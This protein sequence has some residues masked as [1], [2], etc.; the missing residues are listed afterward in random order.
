[1]G[2]LPTSVHKLIQS[3]LFFCYFSNFGFSSSRFSCKSK[4]QR[5][6]FY[7]K[8]SE[9][10]DE[11]LSNLTSHSQISNVIVAPPFLFLLSSPPPAPPISADLASGGKTKSKSLEIFHFN[12][13]CD[14]QFS[15]NQ[16]L[17]WKWATERKLIIIKMLIIN[18]TFACDKHT[19]EQQQLVTLIL[20]WHAKTVFATASF[21]NLSFVDDATGKLNNPRGK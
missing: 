5:T 21:V 17:V 3:S 10:K 19:E 16:K 20:P 13:Q 2:K 14:Q 4:S 7:R 18:K 9:R 15:Q 8:R 12:D 6:T 1:M 11:T